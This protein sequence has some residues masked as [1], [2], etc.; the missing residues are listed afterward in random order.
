MTERKDVEMKK[1]NFENGGVERWA[2]KV[3]PCLVV[4]IIVRGVL[5]GAA[6]G[7]ASM[8]AHGS[9]LSAA[10]IAAS[11][12]Q[13]A[14][15]DAL[16]AVTSLRR[17]GAVDLS[18]PMFG[19]L[20]G[21]WTVLSKPGTKGYQLADFG[22]GATATGWNGARGWEESMMG[23]RDLAPAEVAINRVNWDVHLLAALER[24]GKLGAL[25]RAAD[26]EIDGQ[27]HY[28]LE[29]A[30]E[31][32]LSAD[33]GTRVFVHPE[34][35]QVTRI[36]MTLLIPEMGSTAV[37]HDYSNYVAVEIP[38]SGSVRLPQRIEQS[39]ENVFDLT[40]VLAETEVN[41]AVDEQRFEPPGA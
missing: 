21:T 23:L 30:P 22:Q 12:R 2:R 31:G 34:S 40:I 37:V 20:S 15:G 36:Q 41:G 3:G 4:A 7:E 35:F 17:E 25:R 29:V 10:E 11:A 19:E 13:A 16:L 24:E 38:G 27:V 18:S 28:V 1:R 14:G 8:G 5:S 33:V 26:A 6:P 9:D 39:I 32:A